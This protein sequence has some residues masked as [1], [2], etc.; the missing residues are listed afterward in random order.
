MR[1]QVIVLM[2]LALAGPAMAGDEMSGL[3]K[4]PNG[5]LVLVAP[6][7]KDFCVTAQTAPYKGRSVGQLAPSG[8]GKFTGKLTDLKSGK[9][10]SGKASY[11]GKTLTVAGCVLGGLACKSES[12]LRQ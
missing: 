9:T 6:C 8:A 2:A 1:G 12:W 5:N 11:D 3:Y 4:R 10:Y 7:G